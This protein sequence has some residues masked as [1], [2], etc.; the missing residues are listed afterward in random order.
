MK[1]EE[2]GNLV[3]GKPE[4]KWCYG[5]RE[6]GTPVFKTSKDYSIEKYPYPVITTAK[7]TNAWYVFHTICIKYNPKIGALRYYGKKLR[8]ARAFLEQ[9]K[10][11]NN[12]AMVNLYKLMD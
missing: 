8:K 11:P 12:R 7:K 9:I 10:N 4:R 1:I 5:Y 2:T 6:D 3:N